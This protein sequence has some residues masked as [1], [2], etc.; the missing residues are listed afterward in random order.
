MVKKPNSSAEKY[1]HKKY[2][3]FSLP[4]CGGSV[5]RY[6]RVLTLESDGRLRQ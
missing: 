2:D 4:I 6:V 1:M 5:R 3:N